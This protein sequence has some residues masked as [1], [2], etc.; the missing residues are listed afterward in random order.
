M[1]LEERILIPAIDDFGYK[2][3]RSNIFT[4]EVTKYWKVNDKMKLPEDINE[5]KA[6]IEEIIKIMI[7]RMSD[8]P[9]SLRKHAA[10]QAE[11]IVDRFNVVFCYISGSL[12]VASAGFGIKV[13]DIIIKE[14]NISLGISKY[15]YNL[16]DY[17]IV[18]TGT[19]VFKVEVF[20]EVQIEDG[21]IGYV[22]ASHPHINFVNI[23]WGNMQLSVYEPVFAG[24]FLT[25][26]L[27]MISFLKNY[28]SGSPFDH[29][30]DYIR[31]TFRLN[32]DNYCVPNPSMGMR[33]RYY[34]V[35]NIIAPRFTLSR[36]SIGHPLFA[37]DDDKQ[38]YLEM[39]K[40]NLKDHKDGILPRKAMKFHE[41]KRYINNRA[42]IGM[43]PFIMRL[44]NEYDMSFM[45]AF[46]TSVRIIEELN[47]VMSQTYAKRW[48]GTVMKKSEFNNLVSWAH[49]PFMHKA[50]D[51]NSGYQAKYGFHNGQN[52]IEQYAMLLR[53]DVKIINTFR[54]TDFKGQLRYH[55][56]SIEAHIH[57]FKTLNKI[58]DISV[59]LDGKTMYS[60]K[61]LKQM[62]K[63]NCKSL[64]EA[65]KI[66]H[67]NYNNAKYV[68]A[69]IITE[70]LN[71]EKEKVKNEASNCRPNATKDRLPF[72]SL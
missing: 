15:E 29:I 51:L 16:G 54:I 57:I 55:N 32:W 67:M 35:D 69:K 26:L 65:I 42:Y 10:Q 34:R 5:Q 12:S 44:I 17:I 40:S 61:K 8:I 45:Q 19:F 18:F 14:N 39:N 3:Y 11:M 72:K 47:T 30:E 46:Y 36:P 27:A 9:N 58:E 56:M 13:E 24:N 22:Q 66:S 52:K 28:N 41:Y 71:K 70:I 2:N 25:G 20:Q 33:N 53:Q 60:E 50:Y 38:L 63:E 49:S 68:E 37:H 7:L 62:K 59:Y 1:N 4:D 48:P 6:L 21:S 23:C 31:P 43:M 64:R